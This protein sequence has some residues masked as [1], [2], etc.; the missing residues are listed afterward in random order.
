MNYFSKSIAIFFLFFFSFNPLLIASEKTAF[1]DIDFIIQNSNIG[2]K[3]L[4]DIND[5]NQKNINQ[6]KKKN[7]KLKELEIEIKNKENIISK[8]DFNDEIKNFQK[9]V[10]DYTNE[11]NQKVREFNDFKQKELEKVFKLFNPIISSYMKKNSVN[12]LFDSKN[13]IM[14]NTES[15]LTENILEIINNEIK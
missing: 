6:L 5:L 3:T 2:K 14:G 12:I 11:K 8:K 15:N 7:K 13:I 1:I 10:Q 4:K 9:K